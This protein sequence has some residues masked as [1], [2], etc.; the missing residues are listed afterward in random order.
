MFV[1]KLEGSE[2][3]GHV[4]SGGQ[5]LG[6]QRPCGRHVEGAE[7]CSAV[8]LEHSGEEGMRPERAGA[9]A[10]PVDRAVDV[11]FHLSVVQGFEQRTNTTG[12]LLQN[13][14]SGHQVMGQR[15][16]PEGQ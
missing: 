2:G 6:V 16:K 4:G 10:G 14:H 9:G 8:W 3:E 1:Q 5:H 15:Q 13:S 11:G 12:F 7:V